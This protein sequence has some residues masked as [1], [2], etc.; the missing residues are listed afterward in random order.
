M[1]DKKSERSTA[2]LA[3]GDTEAAKEVKQKGATE[4]ESQSAME[5][6]GDTAERNRKPEEVNSNK[7]GKR[8]HQEEEEE[9][10]VEEYIRTLEP[11]EQEDAKEVTEAAATEV[12]TEMKARITSINKSIAL[13]RKA[14]KQDNDIAEVGVFTLRAKAQLSEEQWQRIEANKV[15]ALE[16]K[17]PTIVGMTRETNDLTSR[18]CRRQHLQ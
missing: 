12:S 5:S 1:K 16:R 13:H 9:F 10:N 14:R 7:E 2:Q 4:T 3:E 8:K 18:R 11:T 6:L 15:A 17:A